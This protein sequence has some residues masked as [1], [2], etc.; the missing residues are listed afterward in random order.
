MPNVNLGLQCAGSSWM[1][2][3]KD[4]SSFPAA[5]STVVST[6]RT[7]RV[8]RVCPPRVLR[9]WDPT[10]RS[11]ALTSTMAHSTMHVSVWLEMNAAVRRLNF[12]LTYISLANLRWTTLWLQI[13]RRRAGSNRWGQPPITSTKRRAGTNESYNRTPATRW[14]WARYV[15]GE[16]A[17]K[18]K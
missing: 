8:G 13:S 11:P 18:H 15:T 1:L 7:S 10:E 2:W 14:C 9:Q 3:G 17:W 16:R 4:S 5:T 12:W 6:I